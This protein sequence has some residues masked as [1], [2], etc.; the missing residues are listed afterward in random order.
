MDGKYFLQ[1]IEI[2]VNFFRK[3]ELSIREI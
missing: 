3:G 2:F 1:M